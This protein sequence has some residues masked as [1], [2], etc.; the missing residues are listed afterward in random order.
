MIPKTGLWLLMAAA[1]VSNGEALFP[2]AKI[3]GDGTNSITAGV[4]AVVNGPSNPAHKDGIS[5]MMEKGMWEE[6]ASHES[7]SE[8]TGMQPAYSP[9]HMTKNLK[10]GYRAAWRFND[11]IRPE[12]GGSDPALGF[13]I[14]ESG[15]FSAKHF[16]AG[17]DKQIDSA[18]YTDGSLSETCWQ[19]R[20]YSNLSQTLTPPNN[21][22]KIIFQTPPRPANDKIEKE[23]GLPGA[24]MALGGGAVCSYTDR[25]VSTSQ[26][27]SEPQKKT[28]AETSGSIGIAPTFTAVLPRP[29][30]AAGKL[31]VMPQTVR[32]ESGTLQCV[33]KNYIENRSA[34]EPHNSVFVV[35]EWYEET[36]TKNIS[37]L[38]I[39]GL[40]VNF[41]A[42]VVSV[43]RTIPAGK[44]P[45]ALPIPAEE[46][47]RSDDPEIYLTKKEE[48]QTRVAAY[49][50]S[51][52]ISLPGM[53]RVK[54]TTYRW[55]DTGTY[56]VESWR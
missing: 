21:T 14:A 50:I 22:A 38:E 44:Y 17:E 2:A 52:V 47:M 1:L 18:E 16:I 9:S 39:G 41:A 7:Q 56:A 3:S 32:T 45:D 15:S 51:R 29:G 4:A 54:I 5:L 40:R 33:C 6:V 49:D 11:T 34:Q 19:T 8:D 35:S 46:T 12:R 13:T 36:V 26:Y 25:V 53:S 31:S 28:L 55:S 24:G 10:Q 27:N 20:S 30:S 42:V 48:F 23:S 37:Y 43:K